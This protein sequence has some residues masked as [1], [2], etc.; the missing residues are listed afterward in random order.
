MA[1]ALRCPILPAL[2]V[3]GCCGCSFA[4]WLSMPP[5]KVADDQYVGMSCDELRSEND[6]LLAEAVD[7][8][9]Q[10]SPGEDLRKKD[11]AY[12]SGE[13][14]ALNRVRNAKKC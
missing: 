6:R 9:P 1:R 8:R 2:L 13:M 10:L 5:A 3:L 11:F 12:V 7:L 4:P 14:D